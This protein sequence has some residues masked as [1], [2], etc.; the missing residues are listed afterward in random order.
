MKLKK[1][2]KI[3]K[4]HSKWRRVEISNR[5]SMKYKSDVVWKAV[6]TL[7]EDVSYNVKVEKLINAMSYPTESGFSNV[8]IKCNVPVKT[9][10][11]DIGGWHGK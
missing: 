5:P 1:A 11:V 9:H 8:S 2:I 3:L 4:H 6:D 10:F 7:V